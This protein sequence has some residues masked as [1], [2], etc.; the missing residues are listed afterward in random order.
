MQKKFPGAQEQ[1]AQGGH[2]FGPLTTF[3]AAYPHVTGLDVEVLAS[4]VGFGETETYS[5]SLYNPPGQY[6]PC[7]NPNCSGGGFHVGVFLGDLVHRRAATGETRGG[8][9]GREKIGKT[10]RRCL[11]GFV[12]KATLEYVAEKEDSPSEGA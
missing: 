6:S 11:Y 9:V 4:P 10:T 12:A 1:L 7:P 2:A 3:R 5:Y 8:C